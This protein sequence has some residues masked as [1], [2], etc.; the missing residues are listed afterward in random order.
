MAIRIA[1][2][3]AAETKIDSRFPVV[4]SAVLSFKVVDFLLP[5]AAPFTSRANRPNKAN[6]L[7]PFCSSVCVCVC[8]CVRERDRERERERVTVEERKMG[9]ERETVYVCV[10]ERERRRD[11][12][13]DRQT[14]RQMVT[15]KE[16]NGERERNCVCV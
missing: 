15:V 11:R 5:R 1:F 10:R 7:R 13:R 6:R 2:E 16:R 12:E 9:K 4:L 8:V 3:T 14:I